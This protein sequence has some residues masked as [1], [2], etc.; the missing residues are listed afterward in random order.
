[1]SNIQLV[2]R[3]STR[4][5]SSC[6]V[7]MSCVIAKFGLAKVRHIS[8]PYAARQD[9][10]LRPLRR[11][12][13]QLSFTRISC[14]TTQPFICF[15]L[16]VIVQDVFRVEFLFGWPER[17][18]RRRTAVWQCPGTTAAATTTKCLPQCAANRVW[19]CSSSAAKLHGLSYAGPSYRLSAPAAAITADN[20]RRSAATK[21]VQSSAATAE[22]P[23]RGS[24]NASDPFS[25]P[26][27]ERS[28]AAAAATKPSGAASET[29]AD[30][31]LAD[32]RQLQDHRFNP[33]SRSQSR[34]IEDWCQDS[35]CAALIYY[36]NRSVEI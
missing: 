27:P 14:I 1:M 24:S 6:I 30:R 4:A 7:Q 17:E 3:R 22:L 19:S 21:P 23:D 8:A 34:E 35:E 10:P 28:T 36:G 11:P 26:E 9:R 32:G 12:H 16:T 29:T 13:F 25:I 5:L 20:I 31:I 33:S 18:A 2:G 15:T